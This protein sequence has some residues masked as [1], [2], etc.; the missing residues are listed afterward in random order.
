M[1]P[2]G[3]SFDYFLT[4][5][6][7]RGGVD[8]FGYQLGE[9]F[10]TCCSANGP[11]G[12]AQIPLHTVMQQK[13]RL[14]I[15]LYFEGTYSFPQLADITL[16]TRY[17][18]EPKATIIVHPKTNTPFELAI[19]IPHGMEQVTL[20]CGEMVYHPKAD[21]FFYIKRV[22]R[23]GDVVTLSG[24]FPVLCHLSRKTSEPQ[25]TPK[26]I[27]TKGPLVLARDSRLDQTLGNGFCFEE[28]PAYEV[29]PASEREHIL[30][31]CQGSLFCDYA[32]AGQFR[33][34]SDTFESWL[35]TT[36]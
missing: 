14:A 21:N 10:L 6:G 30:V 24:Q 20:Q 17:P 13:D 27:L 7:K 4:F 26:V 25:Y 16:S 22:W 35:L 33:D 28:K 36:T 29:L 8:N 18:Y 32:S 31:Q 23:E 15:C 19:R 11:M 5:A 2:D 3:S 34:D 12:L 9:Q 1:H